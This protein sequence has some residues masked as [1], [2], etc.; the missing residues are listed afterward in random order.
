MNEK[1]RLSTVIFLLFMLIPNMYNLSY[2]NGTNQKVLI[3]EHL[4][5][6]GNKKEKWGC[7]FEIREPA[8]S[9]I[10]RMVTETCL[11]ISSFGLGSFCIKIFPVENLFWLR[12]P[13]FNPKRNHSTVATVYVHFAKKGQKSDLSDLSKNLI[14][15]NTISWCIKS[16]LERIYFRK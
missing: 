3:Q 15:L 2:L 16:A 14:F 6:F 5:S 7:L 13:H 12:L 9:V 10:L 8:V 1:R 4:H 11:F